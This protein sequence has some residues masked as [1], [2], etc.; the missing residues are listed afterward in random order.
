VSILRVIL[1]LFRALFRDRSR[2]ALENLALRP[3][4]SS[5]R[6][7]ENVRILKEYVLYYNKSRPHL[8]LERNAPIPRDVEPPP[9]GPV[10]ALPEVGGLTSRVSRGPGLRREER[11]RPQS[12]SSA[13]ASTQ[14]PLG[15]DRGPHEPVA[16]GL[17]NLLPAGQNFQQGTPQSLVPASTPTEKRHQ[18]SMVHRTLL[19]NYC[20]PCD[21]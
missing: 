8:S 15:E 12:P 10:V 1:L 11:I 4:A 9:Q 19:R 17:I 16:V 2:L 20:G 18:V 7:A 5:G 14:A 21:P 3:R 6:S 13:V